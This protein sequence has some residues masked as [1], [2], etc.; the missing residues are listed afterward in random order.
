M[1]RSE[2]LEQ[3]RHE[4]RMSV[5]TFLIEGILTGLMAMGLF[6]MAMHV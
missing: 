5:V 1:L 3:E 2:M 4:K 6:W